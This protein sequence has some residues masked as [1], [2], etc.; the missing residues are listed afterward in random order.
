VKE[1][2]KCCECGIEVVR[3]VNFLDAADQ[4]M[5]DS[6]DPGVYCL[7]LALP[8]GDRDVV[9]LQDCVNEYTLP[10]LPIECRCSTKGC[11]SQTREMRYTLRDEPPLI[12]L[13]LKRWGTDLQRKTCSILAP[14]VLDVTTLCPEAKAPYELYG[15]VLHTGIHANS[16][17]YRTRQS[18]QPRSPLTLVQQ[19]RG[20]ARPVQQC[21]SA[22][23][24]AQRYQK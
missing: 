6:L 21:N 22:P 24:G 8:P 2:H 3:A 17:H 15:A 16:G 18:P 10:S 20:P 14:P 19:M 7:E 4:G 1:Q 23:G 11:A 13:Q 9:N 5:H 12:M